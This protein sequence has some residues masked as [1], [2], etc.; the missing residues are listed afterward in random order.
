MTI[1][2][3]K[4]TEKTYRKFLVSSCHRWHLVKRKTK[5]KTE[6]RRTHMTVKQEENKEKKNRFICKSH[7]FI[8]CSHTYRCSQITFIQEE[9]KGKNWFYSCAN[10]KYPFV[11]RWQLAKKQTKR[12]TYWFFCKW[13]VFSYSQ[14]IV[15]RKTNRTTDWFICKCHISCSQMTAEMNTK[16][17]ISLER[18]KAGKSWHTEKK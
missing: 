16:R 5:T 9:D 17:W 6:S 4:S 2:Q 7:V 14:M 12:I 10:I 3:D 13:H 8:C 18:K 11:Y 15:K 1:T